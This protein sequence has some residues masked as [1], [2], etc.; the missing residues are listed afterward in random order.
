[1]QG[2]SLP[3]LLALSA[4]EVGRTSGYGGVFV[5]DVKLSELKRALAGAGIASEFRGGALY[6][7]GRVVVRRP[8]GEAGVVLEGAPGEEY[9]RVRDAVYQQMHIC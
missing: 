1:M 3:Q 2:G 4:D 9:Y 5:G 8:A 7:A 6:C